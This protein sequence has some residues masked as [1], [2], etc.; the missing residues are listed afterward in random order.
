MNFKNVKV[1]NF[2]MCGGN[3]YVDDGSNQGAYALAPVNGKATGRVGTPGPA[4]T[5]E[6]ARISVAWCAEQMKSDTTCS[7]HFIGVVKDDGQCYCAQSSN[8]DDECETLETNNYLFERMLPECTV[9]H[10]NKL[11][12]TAC[13][14]LPGFKGA[15]TW[16]NRATSSTC[17]LTECTGLDSLANGLVS[18]SRS[19]QHGSVATLACDTGFQLQ[20][21]SSVACS[22]PSADASWA[23]PSP[24]PR[25]TGTLL[26][27]L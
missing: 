14:C 17:T 12:G 9:A 21:S 10:S 23:V 13:K 5:L 3:K 27:R 7:T 18:K 8:T 16:S 2:W 19:N 4:I 11:P 26:R 1:G 20:G 24:A 15:I 6:E 22:A 25:C